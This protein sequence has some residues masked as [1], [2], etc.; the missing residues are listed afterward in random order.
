MRDAIDKFLADSGR[1][2]SGLDEL[3]QKRY[4]RAVPPD[5]ITDSTTTWVVVPPPD[6][7]V[8][9]VYDV[10]SGAPGTSISGEAYENW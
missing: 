7:Q 6:A 10:R 8:P 1:Y 9:G 5:P 4:L 2:P 3:A